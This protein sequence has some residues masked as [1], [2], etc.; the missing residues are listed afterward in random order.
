[1]E[2]LPRLRF[3]AQH[4]SGG[5]ESIQQ[6]VGLTLEQARCISAGHLGK[7]IPHLAFRDNTSYNHRLEY[8]DQR[9]QEWRVA[10]VF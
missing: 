9:R 6:F 10:A 5:R 2:P 4:R 3:I 7:L 1:M 8:F